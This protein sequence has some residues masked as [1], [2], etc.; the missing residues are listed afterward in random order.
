MLVDKINGFFGKLIS[1][2]LILTTQ[3]MTAHIAYSQDEFY[4]AIQEA[5]EFSLILKNSRS[6]PSLDANGSLSFG[7]EVIF[8]SKDLTGQKEGDYIPSNTDTFGDDTATLIAGQ[9]AQNHYESIDPNDATNSGEKAYHIIKNSFSAQKPD[10]SNDPLWNETDYVF[11]NIEEIATNFAKCVVSK[12]LVKVGEQLHVPVYR[13]CERLP[14]IEETLYIS[15]D[16]RVGVIKHKS[17]P[18]NLQSCG[19]GCMRVW[20]GTVG[21]DY[22][23]GWCTIY[24]EQMSLEIIQP[25]KIRF[26]K[27]E[28]SK[29]DD[30]HQVY[31]NNSKVYNGPNANFPPETRGSCELSVSW[32]LYPNINITNYFRSVP[33]G[34]ELKFKTRTSVAGRGE[35]YSQ[36]L[37]YYDHKSTI[38]NDVWS[39]NESIEK[40]LEIKRQMEDGFCE[41]KFTCKES[42]TLNSSGCATVNGFYVCEDDFQ[43]NPLNVLGIS[44]FCKSVEVTSNCN[45]NEGEICW[46]N[47]SGEEICI[48]NDTVERN[49]CEKY[50]NDPTCAYIKTECVEGAQGASGNCYV[51]EDTFDCGFTVNDGTTAEEDVV[52]CDGE[53]QCVG[54]TCYNLERD[55]PNDEFAKAN[56]YLEM[57]S[58]ARNDMKCEGVPNAPYN[59]DSPPDQYN[60]IP[61]CANEGYIYYPSTQQCIKQIDCDYSE[62]DFYVTSQRD[63]IQLVKNAS[64]LVENQ[65][66]PVCVPVSKN[67]QTY[68]CGD[69]MKKAGT[70]TFHQICTSAITDVIPHGCPNDEH[71]LNPQTGFC[72]VPPIPVCPDGYHIIEGND[73]FSVDDDVCRERNGCNYANETYNSPPNSCVL[74][75]QAHL[76]CPQSFPLWNNNEKRCSS[77]LINASNPTGSTETMSG[78]SSLIQENEE[79]SDPITQASMLSYIDGNVGKMMRDA[80]ENKEAYEQ[81]Q[82]MLLGSSI[83]QQ[84][85]GS[86]SKVSTTNQTNVICEI[87]S[88]EAKECKIAVGGTQNCCESPTAVSLGDY[89]KLTKT[90]MLM[91][92]ITAQTGLIEGY[93]GAWSYLEKGGETAWDAVSS[94]WSSPADT[95]TQNAVGGGMMETFNQ[96]VMNYTN[97]F[98]TNNFGEQVAGMFFKAQGEIGQQSAIKASPQMAAI[99]NT[100]MYCYYAYLAYVVFNLLVNIIY[101]C[102]EEELDLAMKVEL[103]STHYLGSYCK[104]KILGACIERRKVYCTFDSPLSRIVMEQV[105]MQPEMNLDWG[106]TSNPNCQ[107][108]KLEDIDLVDWDRVNLDEW[109]AILIETDNMPNQK[110]INL[111]ALTGSGS[112]LNISDE[113]PRENALENIEKRF[114]DTDIDNTKRQAYESGWNNNQ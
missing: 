86:S 83:S 19:D 66:L 109:T 79:K 75:K 113:N 61:T 98:L 108:L 58:W 17:G 9:N 44:P 6:L 84:A 112:I 34:G 13:Q 42:P 7:G 78:F 26:A 36:L 28:R 73:P 63:G 38:Y 74:Y 91:D 11:D 70:D 103:L 35:G 69:A 15:H 25:D 14:A 80:T 24:Q 101:E 8:N 12:E 33:Q 32:N 51:Q 30:Y 59:A 60:P 55:L 111:E 65:N 53:L 67:G 31:I 99:G 95:V 41:A 1:W 88:G 46:E 23:G 50:E 71:I 96:A 54:E 87:F 114:E 47:M 57:L 48:D 52:I 90:M 5:N 72:E 97:D 62:N 37:I 16:Y 20:I 4:N 89:I 3:G 68:T 27:L 81:G 92:G 77:E 40:A 56:A 85:F 64:I 10:L 106:T 104:S 100:L 107:G 2:F 22:W 49:T 82:Q 93:N 94:L 39:D 110:D 102:E 76:T 29:F 105:Y 43:N 45:F 21:D 18:M